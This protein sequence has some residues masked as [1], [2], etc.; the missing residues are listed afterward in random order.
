MLY[1]N[2]YQKS[3]QLIKPIRLISFL[4]SSTKAGTQFR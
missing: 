1:P 2:D 4:F 3:V